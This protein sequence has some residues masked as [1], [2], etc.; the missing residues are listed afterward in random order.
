MKHHSQLI[1]DTYSLGE[2]PSVNKQ[3]NIGF[4][5]F[6]LDTQRILLNCRQAIFAT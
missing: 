2:M 3:T 4:K 5:A 1:T 6:A